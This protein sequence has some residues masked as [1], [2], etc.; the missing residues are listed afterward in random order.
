MI[1]KDNNNSNHTNNNKVNNIINNKYSIEGLG[2]WE[3]IEVFKYI[4]EKKELLWF[5]GRFLYF[6]DFF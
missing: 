6:V 1:I 3:S 5:F 2:V 4:V